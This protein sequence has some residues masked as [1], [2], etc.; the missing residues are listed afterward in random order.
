MNNHMENI[1][2]LKDNS[3]D[4]NKYID[5]IGDEVKNVKNIYNTGNLLLDIILYEKSKICTERNVD[6]KVGIDFSKYEFLDM[7]DITSIFSNLKMYVKAFNQTLVMITHNDDI[8]NM[9][10]MVVTIKD[11]KVLS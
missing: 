8:A 9:A 4:I 11:G 6:F 7:I 1:K 5:N 2:R 3:E 10:D